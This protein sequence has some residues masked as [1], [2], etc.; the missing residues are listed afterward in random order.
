MQ[1]TQVVN[2]TTK[3]VY[4][5]K[6]PGLSL[7]VQNLVDGTS[8]VLSDGR[9]VTLI[10]TA[11]NY[12]LM[13]LWIVSS[14]AVP[15]TV[16]W[17]LGISGYQ[18]P[19][20]GVPTSG[21]ATYVSGA[22]GSSPNSGLVSPTT[23]GVYGLVF[24]PSGS[25]VVTGDIRG[26]ASVNVNFATANVTGSLTSMTSSIAGLDTAPVPWNSVALAGNLTGATVQ[27]TTSV[28]TAPTD[29]LA[30]GSGATGTF[31]GALFGPNAKELGASWNLYDPAGNGKTAIGV[32]GAIAP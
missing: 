26:Q 10:T 16:Y 1:G 28:T 22:P 29:L 23:G 8:A 7:D 5:L 27:G 18:T 19:T 25:L 20:S 2:G 6:E 17:G 32:L 14:N 31:T 4:Q 30:L 13:G 24:V 11:L 21:S 3:N 15:D 9:R 12:T